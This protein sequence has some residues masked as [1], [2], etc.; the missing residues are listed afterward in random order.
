[1]KKTIIQYLSTATVVWRILIPVLGAGALSACTT[2]SVEYSISHQGISRDETE[3]LKAKPEVFVEVETIESGTWEVDLGDLLNLENP[4]AIAAGLEDKPE[5]IQIYLHRF[6]HPKFG[7]YYFD[8]GFEDRFRT[9]RDELPISSLVRSAIDLDKLKIKTTVKDYLK[10]SGSKPKGI[11][12]SHLHLD[13]V[14]GLLDFPNDVPVFVGPG[15]IQ[16]ISFEHLFTRG[17]IDDFIGE[18]RVREL[19]FPEKNGKYFDGYLDFFGDGSLWVLWVPG[20]TEGSIAVL[21]NTTSGPVIFTGD[22]C[23]TRWGWDH[24]VE[25]GNFS[26]DIPRGAKSLQSLIWLAKRDP[27][28]VVHLGHQ[29]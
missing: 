17:T 12:L 18:K 11:I 20:H 1:M 19:Q 8:S 27:R 7:D 16:E 3:F 26:A 9:D 2:S 6:H 21:A 25:P 28:S 15:E 22:A 24:G 13:H 5:P 29:H 4:K 23:H 10:S 14:M